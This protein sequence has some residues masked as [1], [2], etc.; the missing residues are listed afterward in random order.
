[1][2]THLGLQ[3]LGYWVLLG[4]SCLFSAAESALVCLGRTDAVEGSK[5]IERW[6]KHPNRY[7]ITVRLANMMVVIGAALTGQAFLYGL[8]LKMGKDYPLA[9]ASGITFVSTVVLLQLLSR[10]LAAVYGR[11]RAQTLAVRAVQ[12]L[13]VFYYSFLWIPVK[14]IA[15]LHK[16]LFRLAGISVDPEQL[17]KKEEELKSLLENGTEATSLLE[18]EQSELIHSIF[19]FGDTVAREVM[20]PRTEMDCVRADSDLREVMRF[21]TEVGHSRIPVY[22]GKLDNI[23]GILYAKDLLKYWK[24]HQESEE[25]Q[26]KTNHAEYSLKTFMRPVHFVPEN[27]SL[28]DLLKNFQVKKAHLAV[29]V[30]EYG[31][32]AGLITIEDVLEEIVGEIQDEY[33]LEEELYSVQDDG[34]V[35]LDAKMPVDEIAEH[36]NIHLEGKDYDT[37]GGFIFD[38]VGDVPT[39]G[40]EILHDGIKI[41][42][43]EADRRHVIKAKIEKQISGENQ[44]GSP[45]D[46]C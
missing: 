4:A 19:E 28:N 25:K 37:L 17:L 10:N 7:L 21:V 36:L 20:V 38:R 6:L 31:G 3:F 23:V 11:K 30:D 2:D 42:V 41:T 18:E 22:Q 44:Q 39:V 14:F 9:L 15:I 35:L 32:T 1:M 43:L 24:D 12:V 5:A 33:D 8:L 29:V 46:Q 45:N 40:R 34:S 13:E 26:R 16:F 27:K